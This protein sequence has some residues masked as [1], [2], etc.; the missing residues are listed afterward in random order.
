MDRPSRDLA[1][2]TDRGSPQH[3]RTRKEGGAR[4]TS[5][6]S[7]GSRAGLPGARPAD[8]GG[9]APP[10]RSNWLKARDGERES[11]GARVECL[12]L[13]AGPPRGCYDYSDSGSSQGPSSAMRPPNK[14]RPR[15]P[16]GPARPPCAM[17]PCGKCYATPTK[18]TPR[19]PPWP[20]DLLELQEPCPLRSS[21][22]SEACTTIHIFGTG[23]AYLKLANQ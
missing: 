15:P 2:W 8:R 14:I 16:C 23:C 13:A 10:R 21:L 17:P 12:T 19:G 4:P 5:R 9:F 18:P 22:S 11:A 20:P 6:D 7:A 1:Q 3:N